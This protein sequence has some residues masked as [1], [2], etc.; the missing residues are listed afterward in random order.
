M[1]SSDVPRQAPCA[2]QTGFAQ[3]NRWTEGI[4]GGKRGFTAEEKVG[5]L[6]AELGER[7]AGLVVGG[8]SCWLVSCEKLAGWVRREADILETSLALALGPLS[9]DGITR[10]LFL[11]L[12]SGFL[13]L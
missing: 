6:L 3:A 1:H 12:K 7:G 13:C 11:G 5:I 4:L 8:I 9:R 10:E 2:G